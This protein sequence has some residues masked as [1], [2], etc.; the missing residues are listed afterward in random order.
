MK[1]TRSQPQTWLGS[2]SRQRRM[3]L[4]SIAVLLALLGAIVLYQRFQMPLAPA[5]PIE[6]IELPPTSA[7]GDPTA[8]PAAQEE[9]PQEVAAS[10]EEPPQWLSH[11]VPGQAPVLKLYGSIDDAYGD[12]REYSAI[13]YDISP[14]QPV[15]AAAKGV[16]GLIENDPADGLVLEIRHGEQLTTRY[17]G[18][19]KVLVAEGDRVESGHVIAETGAPTAARAGM[20]PHLAFE[21]WRNGSPIDPAIMLRD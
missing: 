11:P 2:L 7:G 14:G 16:V 10:P 13:A 15:L 1:P 19:G 12:F 8:V 6:P 21:V 3:A 9:Q 4:V 20:G 18:L 5:R 17:G